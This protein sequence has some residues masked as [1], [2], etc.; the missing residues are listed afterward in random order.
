MQA[1]AFWASQALATEAKDMR[2]QPRPTDNAISFTM[3]FI[4]V[5]P[6]FPV[7]PFGMRRKGQR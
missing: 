5:A 7:T 4:I 3:F 2:E 1:S 6:T